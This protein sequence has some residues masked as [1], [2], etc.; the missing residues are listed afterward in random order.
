MIRF[1]CYIRCILA[2]LPFVA[3]PKV[4]NECFTKLLADESSVITIPQMTRSHGCSESFGFVFSRLKSI[5]Q[6][7]LRR[8]QSTATVGERSRRGTEQ[9][10]TC[11]GRERR[12]GSPLYDNAKRQ[13]STYCLPYFPDLIAYELSGDALPGESHGEN[14]VWVTSPLSELSSDYAQVVGKRDSSEAGES[15]DYTAVGNTAEYSELGKT[16][17]FTRVGGTAN[18]SKVGVK[19]K[20]SGETQGRL[21]NAGENHRHPL[22]SMS[23]EEYTTAFGRADE[24][25]DSSKESINDSNGSSTRG[26]SSSEEN[27]SSSKSSDILPSGTLV[28]FQSSS[29]TRQR[30]PDDQLIADIQRVSARALYSKVK[31]GEL[32]EAEVPELV[33]SSPLSNTTTNL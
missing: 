11:D 4:Q 30:S 24:K 1:R 10:Y 28:N 31:K 6:T 3:Q 8:D 7:A 21:A 15:T 18:Y 22:K 14:R 17:G 32:K 12:R 20:L 5:S 13:D 29:C 23:G 19:T 25:I 2:R 27:T 26:E 33:I 16:T 9:S